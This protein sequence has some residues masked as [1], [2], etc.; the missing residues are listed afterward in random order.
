MGWRVRAIPVAAI[1]VLCLTF[2]GCS[3]DE[4]DAAAPATT[5]VAPAATPLIPCGAK[6][7]VQYANHDGVA[8]NL[9]SLDVWRPPAGADDCSNR[10]LVVWVHGGGWT[11]GD[12]ADAFSDKADFFTAAGYA[13]ASVNYRVTA[14]PPA[15]PT[16]QYP[17]HNNDAADAIAWLVDHASELGVDPDRIVLMGHSAGGGIVAA[18]TTDESYL[19][20]RG[21]ELDAIR[22][23]AQIDGEGYDV[24]YG[25]THPDPLVYETYLI[26]FG[27]DP[28]VWEAAS[29]VTYIAPDKG[30]PANFVA[31]RGPEGRMHMNNELIEALRAADV[32]VTV[33]DAQ[34]LT[35]ET[36]ATN[37][38]A[39][40]D[41][42]ITP[43]VMDFI[44]DCF[45][46]DQ[47]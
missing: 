29:P 46:T 6:A 34:S 24:T 12:K 38:G 45:A 3:P 4:T 1:A 13:Y 15:V 42:T 14:K 36:V 11:G 43:V 7:T 9:N 16:P 35:H 20:T 23:A 26:A 2:A 28:A 8:A 31:A 32:P 25:A 27:D 18:I 39:P 19:E 33:F 5:T 17:V 44:E 47:S 10:P 21:L 41:T 30:I 40:G 37:L 22:C